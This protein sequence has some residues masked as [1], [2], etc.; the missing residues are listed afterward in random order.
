MENLAADNNEINY[1]EDKFDQVIIDET[2]QTKYILK[3]SSSIE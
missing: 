2:D 1:E 3:S